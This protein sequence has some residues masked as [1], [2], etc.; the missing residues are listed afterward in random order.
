MA[1]HRPPL[2]PAKSAMDIGSVSA[3][4]EETTKDTQVREVVTDQKA[5]FVY[6]SALRGHS[7]SN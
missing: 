3:M 4:Y 5:S 1:A 6:L 2:A 7:F